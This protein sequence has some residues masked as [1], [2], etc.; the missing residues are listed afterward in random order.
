[1]K[2]TVWYYWSKIRQQM[3]IATFHCVI[4]EL[5]YWTMQLR[6]FIPVYHRTSGHTSMSQ[7]LRQALPFPATRLA[8][9]LELIMSACRNCCLYSLLY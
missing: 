3:L 9:V 1:M 4:Q 8:L 6:H 5:M 2:C 7:W